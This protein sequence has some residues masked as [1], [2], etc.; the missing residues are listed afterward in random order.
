MRVEGGVHHVQ[1]LQLNVN[2][3]TV[4]ISYISLIKCQKLPLV[5]K[6]ARP[7]KS[8]SKL[9]KLHADRAAEHY[10]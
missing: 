2:L 9:Q 8:C 4:D 1:D 7:T 5:E 6:V 10:L 3:C